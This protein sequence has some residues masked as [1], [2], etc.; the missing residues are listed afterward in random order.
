[1][2]ETKYQIAESIA[3]VGVDPE[4]MV[5]IICTKNESNLTNRSRDMVPEG[6]KVRTDRSS[7]KIDTRMTE[8]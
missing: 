5:R 1:M 8:G 3:V 4:S 7:D 6:Q 2:V